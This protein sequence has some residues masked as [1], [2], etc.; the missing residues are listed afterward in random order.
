VDL[1]STAARKT[2][3]RDQ[4][5]T[6]RNRRSLLEVAESARAIADHLLDTPDVRRAA[7]VAARCTS[8]VASR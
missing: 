6:A 8:G 5:I 4:L 3:L 2:A 7:T 1:D